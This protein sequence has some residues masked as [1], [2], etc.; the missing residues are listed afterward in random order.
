MYGSDSWNDKTVCQSECVHDIS[1]IFSQEP[2]HSF[3]KEW[4]FIGWFQ[5]YIEHV[6]EECQLN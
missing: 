1:V 6:C 5:W 3:T 2:K 4:V